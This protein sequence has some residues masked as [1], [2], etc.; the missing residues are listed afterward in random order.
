MTTSL[1][2]FS[3]SR[4]RN[5]ISASRRTDMVATDPQGLTR[6][7][8]E[9][10]PPEDVHTVVLWTKDP[11]NLCYHERL[12]SQLAQYDHLFLHLTITGLGGTIVEPRV[13]AP[14]TVFSQIEYLIQQFG[15]RRI[16]LRFDPI[17]HFT[18][19]H[20]HRIENLPF[21]KTLAPVA[22]QYHLYDVS[23]SWMQLY[24]KVAKRL[25]RYGIKPVS[26]SPDIRTQEAKWLHNIAQQYGLRLHGC[27]VPGW[28]TSRCIDGE[29]L[30]ELHPRGYPCSTRRAKGQRTLCGCTESYDIGWYHP[31]VHG[32]LYCY[33]NPAETTI[34]TPEKPIPGV[35]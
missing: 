13:P 24:S 27:C 10:A 22:S 7:L 11:R 12:K 9:K 14:S 31:C 2:L 21:F 30:N 15:S 19:A 18:D 3:E 28:P 8:A 32:C 17:V 34:E 4:I 35:T 5:V 20:G 23:L 29:L 25:F 26:I 6:A 16:R 1:D 33:G